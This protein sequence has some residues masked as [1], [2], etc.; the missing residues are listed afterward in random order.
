MRWRPGE[1]L[2]CESRKGFL[3]H[4]FVIDF[5]FGHVSQSS[6]HGLADTEFGGH[7]MIVAPDGTVTRTMQIPAH[8]I[9]SNPAGESFG[10]NGP[11]NTNGNGGL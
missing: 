4:F 6:H 5:Q 7:S 10:S 9:N 2:A 3:F 11:S 1:R 8:I